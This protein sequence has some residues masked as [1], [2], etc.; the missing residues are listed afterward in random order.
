[1]AQHSGIGWI[2]CVLH[3]CERMK[4]GPCTKGK[5]L[6]AQMCPSPIV[7]EKGVESVLYRTGGRPEQ[8]VELLAAL[9]QG[10]YP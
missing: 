8:R 5:V 6:E 4:M 10:A 9:P 2:L 3:E 1:M 7:G